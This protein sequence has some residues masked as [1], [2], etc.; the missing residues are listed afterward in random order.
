MTMKTV[1]QTT[2]A[3]VIPF[4]FTLTSFSQGVFQNLNFESAD[5]SGLSPGG[6]PITNAL[7]FW[8][9]YLGLNPADIV[10][11][12]DVSLGAAAITL[13]GPGSSLSILQGSYTVFLQPQFPS[14][15]PVPAIA[16]MGTVPASAVSIRVY[17][18][19]G[20][21]NPLTSLTFAGQ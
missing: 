4:L 19:S 3:G 9:G 17:S 20:G 14:G 2:F 7:P 5:V 12:T 21:G 18:L 13:Q 6:V 10:F 1:I 8:Q 15:S 11:Y 16:Q